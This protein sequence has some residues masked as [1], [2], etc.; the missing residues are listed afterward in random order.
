MTGAESNL[1]RPTDPVSPSHINVSQKLPHRQSS[2][3][4][5]QIYL[6]T[7]LLDLRPNGI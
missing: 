6:A 2:S 1:G 4:D 5:R 7:S 3:D